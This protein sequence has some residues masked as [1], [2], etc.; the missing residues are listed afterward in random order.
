M[1]EE[2]LSDGRE[3][4]MDTVSPGLAD[5]ALDFV[6]TW[7]RPLPAAKALHNLEQFPRIATVSSP[8]Q[9]HPLSL[10]IT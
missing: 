1:L 9:F 10:I 8:V 6:L 3:W 7:V 2:Q 5:V 4:V